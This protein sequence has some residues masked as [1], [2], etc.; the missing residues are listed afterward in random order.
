[1]R[2]EFKDQDDKVSLKNVDP[3]RAMSMA[4]AFLEA[5]QEEARETGEE[6]T[7]SGLRFE[8]GS[9]VVVTEPN[10]R[11]LAR[12]VERTVAKRLRSA[13]SSRPHIQRLLKR[14]EESKFVAARSVGPKDRTVARFDFRAALA[15]NE[16][17]QVEQTTLR[18]TLLGVEARS[19]TAAARA[20]F[21]NVLTGESMRLQIDIAL[22]SKLVSAFRQE[23]DLVVRLERDVITGE[24][25]GQ[26]LSI[27]LVTVSAA[28]ALTAWTEWFSV[29]GRD[30]ANVSPEQLELERGKDGGDL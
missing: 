4:M 28:D 12:R 13:R 21:V 15:M 5:M 6:L 29:A 30:W 8:T 3:I 2:L 16:P 23:M 19:A 18:A 1:M 7:F 9:V 25:S 14:S 27:D 20:K 22:E 24:L 17:H 26:L 10:N 11:T